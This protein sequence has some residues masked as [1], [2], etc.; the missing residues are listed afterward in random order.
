MLTQGSNGAGDNADGWKGRPDRRVKLQLDVPGSRTGERG[1]VP[2]AKGPGGSGDKP[3]VLIANWQQVE[4]RW[5]GVHSYPTSL[6]VALHL[7]VPERPQ[8][9][10]H[11]QCIVLA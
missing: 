11:R 5:H 9:P 3:A 2:L 10:E 1:P 8:L 6:R 4:R 7:Q